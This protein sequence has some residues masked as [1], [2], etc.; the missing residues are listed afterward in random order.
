MRRAL[1]RLGRA[2]RAGLAA[3]G[4]GRRRAGS[5]GPTRADAMALWHAKAAQADEWLSCGAADPDRV[6]VEPGAGNAPTHPAAPPPGPGTA[7][8]IRRSEPKQ[9]AHQPADAPAGPAAAPMPTAEPPRTPQPARRRP[10]ALER[11]AAT[12]LAAAPRPHQRTDA[13]E[14]A[15]TGVP[16]APGAP[17]VHETAEPASPAPRRARL[18][19]ESE[20]DA[21]R[22]DG[23]AQ[24]RRDI[25][26]RR[27]SPDPNREAAPVRPAV[28]P[29]WPALPERRPPPAVAR[30]AD[31][32]AVAS[33][34]RW[35]A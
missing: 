20:F 2:L 14:P 33:G 32:A 3:L 16:A 24:P 13:E 7:A 21:T 12:A 8:A 34:P 9:P 27:R 29:P 17:R 26:A 19:H 15:R 28:S 23:A 10:P 35:N 30:A 31:L 11:K 18:R 6:G 4:P 22:A 5:T 25:E 1:A